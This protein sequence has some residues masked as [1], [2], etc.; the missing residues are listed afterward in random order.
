MRALRILLVLAVVL[1]GLFAIGD[2]LALREAE[3]EAAS[4]IRVSQGLSS[5][6]AVSIHGFPFLTQVLDKRFEQVDLSM[7]GVAA[8]VGDRQ[9]RVGELTAEL[10]DVRVE[11]DYTRAVAATASGTARISYGELRKISDSDVTLEYGGDGK[12]KVTGTVEILGRKLTRSVLSTVS[13]VDGS[14]IRVRADQVP[15][16]GIPMLEELVRQRTDFDREVGGFPAGL[17]IREVEATADG[18]MVTVGGKDV[19]LTG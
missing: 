6:P 15:G 13:V 7:A 1:G 17:E 5:D 14:T 3:S 11:G 10:R 9:V 8:T 12:I 16:E 2:R 18:L 19:V 4:R